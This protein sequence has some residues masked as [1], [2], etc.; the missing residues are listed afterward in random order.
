MKIL[1][2]SAIELD[3]PGGPR[4][5]ILE[6]VKA[7][8]GSGH[9]ILLLTPRFSQKRLNLPF[10]VVLYPFFGYSFFRRMLSYLFLS[11]ILLRCIYTFKP[12]VLYERQMEFNPFIWL[13]GRILHLPLFIEINGL[14]AEDLQQTD[15]GLIPIFIHEIIEKKELHASEGICCTSL[16]L[17][18][19]IIRKYK[20]MANKVVHIPNGVNLSLFR[21][22]NKREC[23]KRMNLEPGMKYLGYVGTFNHLHDSQQVVES[24]KE[25]RKRTGN[26]G[27]IMVGDG[28]KKEA[29]Q[30]LAAENG[31][32]DSVIFTGS[33]DYE[34]VPV[35]MN[36]FD[37]GLVF[38]SKLRLE[39]EGVVAFK[40]F[41]LLACGCPMVATYKDR[42][43]CDRYSQIAKM[44][45]FTD[46]QN[47]I[48]ETV[49]L[50]QNPYE[51]SRMAERALDF[52]RENISWEKSA[53]H[54]IDFI[55]SKIM[56]V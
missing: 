15:S 37:V 14:M 6:I 43:D 48:D 13:A 32:A 22:T 23:R 44:V 10:K 16:I 40:L 53:A 27:L 1:Y 52:I 47:V 4:T 41:E 26:L 46:K 25:I 42:A 19:K 9:D 2:I 29:C 56:T 36:C 24:F 30:N 49:A 38:A 12:D 7:W 31:L 11:I 28:P 20:K 8:H 54:T 3:V 18:K 17:A 35:I 45:Y 34:D 55:R 21:P 5:H 33:V 50:L 51:A 39:R